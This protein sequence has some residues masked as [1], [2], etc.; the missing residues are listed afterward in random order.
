MA[1]LIAECYIGFAKLLNDEM[2]AFD[3]KDS[4]LFDTLKVASLKTGSASGGAKTSEERTAKEAGV[5]RSALSST[6]K[7]KQFAERLWFCGQSI[8]EISGSLTFYNLPIL[9]QMKVGVLTKSGIQFSSKPILLESQLSNQRIVKDSDNPVKKI[10]A[11]KDRLILSDTGKARARLTL[12]EKMQL[13]GQLNSLLTTSQK[14]S[15]TSFVYSNEQE[16]L[17]AQ[18][19]FVELGRHCLTFSEYVDFDQREYYYNTLCLILRR[20]ELDLG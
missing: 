18:K 4:A 11:L 5:V 10:E 14:S 3:L 20:S 12:Y 19:M 16:L 13:F 1:D 15:M 8:G 6:H 7:Q 17:G 2:R 9:Y